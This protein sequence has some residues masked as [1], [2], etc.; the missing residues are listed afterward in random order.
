MGAVERT[1]P[2]RTE[3]MTTS[4]VAQYLRLA[5]ATIYKLAQAGEIPAIKVGR[6]WRFKKDL[7]DE[8][9]R[10]QAMHNLPSGEIVLEA[11]ES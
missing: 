9:F 4:E 6:T 2:A 11:D 3:I 8:W 7:I 1:E 5:E 10:Q